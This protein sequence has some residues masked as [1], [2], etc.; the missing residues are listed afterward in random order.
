MSIN[1]AGRAA[2]DELRSKPSQ[3]QLQQLM[4]LLQ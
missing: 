1:S 3:Q 2:A 4:L